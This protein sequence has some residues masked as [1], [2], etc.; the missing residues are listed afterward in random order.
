MGLRHHD[1][2]CHVSV[3]A[4]APAFCVNYTAVCLYSRDAWLCVND[5]RRRICELLH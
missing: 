4:A 5:Q 2:Y 3:G 1:V